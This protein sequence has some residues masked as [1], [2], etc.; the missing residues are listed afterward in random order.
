MYVV[1]RVDTTH[2][3]K[4]SKGGTRQ[5]L[6]QPPNQFRFFISSQFQTNQVNLVLNKLPVKHSTLTVPSPSSENT[7]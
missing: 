5:L 6:S 1:Q 2:P 7:S 4:L 3:L